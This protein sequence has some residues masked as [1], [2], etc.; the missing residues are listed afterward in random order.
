MATFGEEIKN[1][2][3]IIPKAI[4]IGLGLTVLIYVGVAWVT[5]GIIDPQIIENSLT[6]LKVAFDV[7]RF[8]DFSFLITIGS[9]IATGS[10]LLALVPGISRILVAMSRDSYL[11][12]VFKTIHKKFNSAYVSEIFTAGTVSYTHLTLPTICSV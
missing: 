12:S 10:V 4:L 5:L 9:T 8:S 3:E 1:P 7:S 2:E 6:P 11:P